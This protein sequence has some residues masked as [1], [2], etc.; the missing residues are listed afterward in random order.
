MEYKI[1]VKIYIYEEWNLLEFFNWYNLRRARKN[2]RP[3]VRMLDARADNNNKNNNNNNN[4][5]NKKKKKKKKKKK[6]N[7]QLYLSRV[8]LDSIKY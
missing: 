6:N 2:V 5:N 4:N 3:E 1:Y 8:A 7:I